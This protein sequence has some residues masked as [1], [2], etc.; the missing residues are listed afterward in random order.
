[1]PEASSDHK[2]KQQ[3][4]ALE[5][6][7]RLLKINEAGL[8]MDQNRFQAIFSSMQDIYFEVDLKGN[9][10]HFNPGLC[11]VL[12]YA[13]E[14]LVG[15]NNREYAIPDVSKRMYQVFNKIFTTGEPAKVTDYQII[16]KA[17]EI[18]Y[19]ELSAY[20]INDDDDNPLGFRGIGRDVSE[21]I[22]IAKKLRE[23]EDWVKKLSEA[24]FSA[25]FIHSN[26]RILDCNL[27]MTR[28]TGY[29]YDELIDMDGLTLCAPESRNI[30]IKAMQSSDEKIYDAV[31]LKKNGTK[32][33]AEVHGKNILYHGVKARVTEFRDISEHKIAE[34]ALR[35]VV[36]DTV[37]Y[38][39]MPTGRKN[40]TSPS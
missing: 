12:G 16:T 5:N 36:S 8:K 9:F 2:L 10:I 14:E 1:M 15:K 24:S 19:L 26:G 17:G 20:L 7:V 4:E 6:E 22:E 13:P 32:I 25:I 28:I 27:E 38:I 3:I 33:P 30:V 35:K 18:R 29:D 23:S 21:R 39:K 31:I 37:N 40:F 34:E 11:D